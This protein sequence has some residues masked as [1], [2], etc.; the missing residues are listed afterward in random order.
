MSWM[1]TFYDQLDRKL[2]IVVPPKRIISLVPSQTELLVDL[3]LIDSL[4][5]VTKFCV[6][7][8]S[9]REKKIVV[10]G[11]KQ[12][13]MDKIRKLAP[14]I[15]LCNKEENTL[16]MVKELEEIAPVHVSDV[17]NID[18]SIELIREYGEI[19][20]AREKASAIA[21]RILDLRNDFKKF[22]E[23]KPVQTVV[24]FIW[25][26]PWMVVGRDTFIDHLL[27]I[28]NFKNIFSENKSR[29]PEVYLKQ[30]ENKK[31]DHI[32]LSTEPFPF[33]DED[34]KEF[35][36]IGRNDCIHIVDGEFFSWY[37]SRLVAAFDYF[38]KLHQNKIHSSSS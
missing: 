7:P 25:K 15:I 8:E 23:G 11:T 3:G 6:H 18:D 22:V 27:K 36:N 24:Y 32:L 28:N 10:G 30:L 9:L 33:K 31:I 2:D 16:E 14:E 34:K 19:F 26:N 38:K 37:G 29:Y 13:H 20:Q 1:K 4:V 17:K 35:K 5:G 21:G 12:V